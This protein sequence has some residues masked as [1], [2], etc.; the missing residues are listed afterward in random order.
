MI[1]LKAQFGKRY[2][3][4]LD[5]SAVGEPRAEHAW[6]YRIACKR[7][8]VSVHGKDT[9]AAWTDRRL[10]KSKLASVPGVK[11]H[12]EG[13][14]EIRVLFPVECLDGVLEVLQPYVRRQLSPEQ[15]Q[16]GA[17]RLRQWR[18]SSAHDTPQDEID[19]PDDPD[20]E[21]T[22]QTTEIAP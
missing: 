14:A 8:F 20:E 10:L 11:V 18:E 16:L 4:T 19:V 1:D 22:D 13:D 7:G 21:S 3:I 6:Y 2:R 17:E 5:P 12:Q 15:R 9:L